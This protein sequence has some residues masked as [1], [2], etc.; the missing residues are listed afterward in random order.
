VNFGASERVGERISDRT[1]AEVVDRPLFLEEVDDLQHLP[2]LLAV[3]VEPAECRSLCPIMA[4][5]TDR[6]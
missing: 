1:D 6:W 3:S 2:A 4:G 5:S